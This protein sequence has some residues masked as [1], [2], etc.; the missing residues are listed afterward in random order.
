MRPSS[1]LASCCMLVA[2]APTPAV[3]SS[4]APPAVAIEDTTHTPQPAVVQPPPREPE[5]APARV[6]PMHREAPIVFQPA[7]PAELRRLAKSLRTVASSNDGRVRVELGCSRGGRIVVD[8]Q[9]RDAPG[10]VTTAEAIAIAPRGDAAAFERAGKITVLELPQ[11]R[12]RGSWTGADPR[13]LDDDTLAFRHGCH[14]VALARGGDT[15]TPLGDACGQPLRVEHGHPRL[16]LTEPA[17]EVGGRR[18]VRA[19]IGLAPGEAAQRVD[20]GDGAFDPVLSHDAAI[21]CATFVHEGQPLLQ[22]RPRAGGS[23]ERVAQ[24]VIGIGQFAPDAARLAFTVG[25]PSA[26][27][28]D[29]F[30]A[31]FD[32]KLVRK[33]GRVAHHRIEFLA[34]S[35]RVLAFDGARGLVFEIDLGVVVPFGDEHDDWVGLWVAH[36]DPDGFVASRLRKRCA[37]LVYVRLPSGGTPTTGEPADD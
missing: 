19:L 6:G 12:V 18:A 36:G 15:P 34:G 37:E 10:S 29:L 2:C 25:E 16:W 7:A 33:L 23:F 11:A 22:C 9:A 3:T 4:T 35:E 14:W 24:G 26:Q 17:D 20:L 28:H 32:T 1:L 13:Y 27:Q 30:V 8:G 31:D 21:V 5:P